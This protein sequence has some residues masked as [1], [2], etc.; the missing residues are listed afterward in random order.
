MI[1]FGLLVPSQRLLT[2]VHYEIDRSEACSEQMGGS[3]S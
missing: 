1:H 3:T 2:E